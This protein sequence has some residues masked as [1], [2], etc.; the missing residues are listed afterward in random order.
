[1]RQSLPPLLT[2]VKSISYHRAFMHIV[3]WE[4]MLTP[5]V[6]ESGNYYLHFTDIKLRPRS[7]ILELVSRKWEV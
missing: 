4:C 3:P 2:V 7:K 6:S 5:T 1:M